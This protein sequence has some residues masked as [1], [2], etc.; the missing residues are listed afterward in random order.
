MKSRLE[1]GPVV[2]LD[3]AQRPLGVDACHARRSR[4]ACVVES[5]PYYRAE[6]HLQS[7]AAMPSRSMSTRTGSA[8]AGVSFA[9]SF[10]S[11]C[12]R[13]VLLAIASC[14]R[15][16]SAAAAR[17][18]AGMASAGLLSAIWR[19]RLAVEE[20]LGLSGAQARDQRLQVAVGEQVEPLAVG[21][22]GR[23]LAVVAVGRQRSDR[24]RLDA[25]EKSC[26]K[27]FEPAVVDR[28]ASGCRRPRE[29]PEPPYS[30]LA[31]FFCCLLS[32]LSSQSCWSLS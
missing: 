32:A 22:P 1:P 25:V 14:P 5:A 27:P 23:R 8:F 16:A 30:E 17:R 31:I 10:A 13:P 12:R 18:P 3:A 2:D 15:P 4:A 7:R 19:P 21:A 26:W 6:R 11:A 9:A 20:G 24:A 28:P 29:I